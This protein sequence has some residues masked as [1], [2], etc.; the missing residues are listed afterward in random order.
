MALSFS[1]RVKKCFF[2]RGGILGV[3]AYFY[4]FFKVKL[5]LFYTI[6]ESQKTNI[7]Y[8]FFIIFNLNSDL[9]FVG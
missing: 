4:I 1:S 2:F 3:C 9:K 7:V 5:F 6:I 8:Y